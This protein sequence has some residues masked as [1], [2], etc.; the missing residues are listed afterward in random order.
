MTAD[1]GPVPVC[2]YCGDETDGTTCDRSACQTF[3]ADLRNATTETP[4]DIAQ[5][6]REDKA[7]DR[8]LWP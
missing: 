1:P 5:F 6:R 2:I 7:L 8:S 4:A 3:E